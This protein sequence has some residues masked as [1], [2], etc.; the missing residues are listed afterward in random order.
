MFMVFVCILASLCI[1]GK[2]KNVFS[3]YKT[4]KKDILSAAV[5]CN[6]KKEE[7]NRLNLLQ[8]SGIC[9]FSLFH[10][11]QAM[12]DRAMSPLLLYDG[13]RGRMCSRHDFIYHKE[14]NFFWIHSISLCNWDECVCPDHPSRNCTGSKSMSNHRGQ[15]GQRSWGGGCC[16]VWATRLQGWASR[17]ALTWP[18]TSR[19][20]VESYIRLV[21]NP[22]RRIWMIFACKLWQSS[23]KVVLLMAAS[24]L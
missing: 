20:H 5:G 19:H 12:S 16:T 14:S 9:P 3:Q 2:M 13:A 8:G 17:S 11:R 22:V 7:K 18:I 21:P 10:A 15:K 23:V 4:K 6:V 1:V 24:P